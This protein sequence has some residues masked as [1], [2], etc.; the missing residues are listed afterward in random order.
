M[1]FGMWIVDWALSGSKEARI[2]LGA[3]WRHLTNIIEL[4]MCGSDATFLSN[5]F[6]H[7]FH[8]LL[9]WICEIKIIKII[10]S[11]SIQHVNTYSDALSA[12]IPLLMVSCSCVQETRKE[13]VMIT[14]SISTL[15]PFCVGSNFWYNA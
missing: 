4:F 15:T 9:P 7:L 6:H 13:H 3:H 8:L 11:E 12:K 2:R 5:Y 14:L 10:Q 1:S